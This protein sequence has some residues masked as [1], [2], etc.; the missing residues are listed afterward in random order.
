MVEDICTHVLILKHGTPQFFG[1]IADV[2]GAFS[3]SGT[4]AS[5]EDIFFKATSDPAAAP[6]EPDYA[7]EAT[8]SALF[9][10]ELPSDVPTSV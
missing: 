9:E 6:S 3:E 10:H 1:P 5:L 8:P 7:T 2:R 4:D